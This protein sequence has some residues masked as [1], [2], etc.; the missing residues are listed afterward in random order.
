MSGQGQPNSS[1]QNQCESKQSGKKSYYPE[2]V[3]SRT[4]I[5]LSFDECLLVNFC[6]PKHP[7]D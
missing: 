3:V 7:F 1:T 5:C 2:T 6:Q 4:N